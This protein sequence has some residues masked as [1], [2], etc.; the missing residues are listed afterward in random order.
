LSL[1][2]KREPL[3]A[4]LAREGGMAFGEPEPTRPAWDASGIHG[5]HRVREWD[6]VTTVEAPGVTG[7]RVQFVAVSANEL[8]VEEGPD[9]V[10]SLAAAVERELA[11]P[12]RAE[13]VRREGELWA[14][15]A[16][17]IELVE[18]PGIT[19][20]ELELATH[21]DERSLLVDGQRAFGSIPA[22]ERPEHVT[23]ARRVDG[24]IWEVEVAPL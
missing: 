2:R 3:H 10:E 18:L 7:E 8:V 19:G 9:D 21:G 5:V 22:L 20:Q 24:E 4:R 1:F 6:V 13:G 17:R 12:Y 11:P 23:R 14:V 15:A 16:R